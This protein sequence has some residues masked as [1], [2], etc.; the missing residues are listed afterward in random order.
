[1]TANRQAHHEDDPDG[2]RLDDPYECEICGESLPE[3][4][5]RCLDCR[6]PVPDHEGGT[7]A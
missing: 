1:M 2:C 6:E 3:G 5:H 7:D 4:G